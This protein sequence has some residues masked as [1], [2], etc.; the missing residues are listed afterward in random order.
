MEK[1]E[2]TTT[3]DSFKDWVRRLQTEC[4]RQGY[5]NQTVDGVPG[6]NTLAGCPT[7]GKRSA[8]NITKLMQER[9]VKLGYSLDPYGA[10]GENGAVTNNAIR[11]FQREKGLDDDAIVGAKTWAALLGLR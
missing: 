7:L 5:S 10:D 2:P 3:A 6:K 1:T 8:G 4:N 11:A 9:L